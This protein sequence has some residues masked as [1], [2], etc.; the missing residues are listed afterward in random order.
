MGVGTCRKGLLNG[1][2][3][4]GKLLFGSKKGR[5]TYRNI[6]K[7]GWSLVAKLVPGA[8]KGAAV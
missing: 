8:P 2:I 7:F 5:F 6:A 1:P 3:F 4:K